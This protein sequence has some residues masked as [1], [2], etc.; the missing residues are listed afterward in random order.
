MAAPSPIALLDNAGG[1]FV[2]DA[3]TNTLK[4]ADGAQARLT[5]RPP[6][7]TVR[8]QV[9][10][11]AGSDLRGRPSP[12]A[13]T[14]VASENVTGTTGTDVLVGGVGKDV[15]NGGAGNDRLAGG[16]GKDVLTGGKGRDTFVFDTKPARRAR[17]GR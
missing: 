6:S 3:T 4:V 13:S 14:D 17:T 10:D 15:F 9:K 11:S 1:R 16:L 2:I 5:S 12:S 8:V 7:H